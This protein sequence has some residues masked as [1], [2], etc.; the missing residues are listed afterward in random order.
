VREIAAE[1]LIFDR[2]DQ[3]K[4]N[5]EYIEPEFNEEEEETV[6]Q[7]R[8]YIWIEGGVIEKK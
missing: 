4:E 3:R 7:G 6:E 1:R 5:G 2:S 8:D